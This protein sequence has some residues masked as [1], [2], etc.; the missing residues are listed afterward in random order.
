[1]KRTKMKNILSQRKIKGLSAAI[2]AFLGLAILLMSANAANAEIIRIIFKKNNPVNPVAS[3][4]RNHLGT[5][6]STK[7]VSDFFRASNIFINGNKFSTSGIF[8]INVTHKVIAVESSNPVS[9]KFSV[10]KFVKTGTSFSFEG[11]RKCFIIS[12]EGSLQTCQPPSQTPPQPPQ[13]LLLPSMSEEELRKNLIARIADNDVEAVRSLVALALSQN[14]GREFFDQK[15][16]DPELIRGHTYLTMIANL[17]G[18]EIF[19]IFLTIRDDRIDVNAP[20]KDEFTPLHT[21]ILARHFDIFSALLERKSLDVNAR[22]EGGTTTLM[23]AASMPSL[24]AESLFKRPE[25]DVDAR[26]RN[27]ESAL[28][29][30]VYMRNLPVV[31]ALVSRNAREQGN[32]EGLTPL[33]I[34][35]RKNFGELIPELL[36]GR[37]ELNAQELLEGIT[38]LHLAVHNADLPTVNGLLRY[39]ELNINLADSYGHTPLHLAVRKGYFE[40]VRALLGREDLDV[41]ARDTETKT[42]PIFIAFMRSNR[43]LIDILLERV[44]V[45]IPN[46]FGETPLTIALKNERPDLAMLTMQKDSNDVN[47][48]DV[49]GITALMIASHLGYYPLV[50]ELI[51]KGAEVNAVASGGGGS[52]ISK[53]AIGKSAL[54]AASSGN[55]AD[56]SIVTIV[57]TLL[58]AGADLNARDAEGNTALSIATKMG[59]IP[60]IAL[61]I[62]SKE[63]ETHGCSSNSLFR[64]CEFYHQLPE[65]PTEEMEAKE[66]A[67]LSTTEE[68]SPVVE[69]P[70][71][72][73]IPAVAVQRK[74]KR[75]KFTPF[76]LNKFA[77]NA[78][79]TTGV[80]LVESEDALS[81]VIEKQYQLWETLF[82]RQNDQNLFFDMHPETPVRPWQYVERFMRMAFLLLTNKQHNGYV[83][84]IPGQGWHSQEHGFSP[85]REA[86]IEFLD[87]EGIPYEI[88]PDNPGRIRIY[89][90]DGRPTSVPVPEET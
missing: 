26:D 46:I 80:P 32:G 71:S 56:A 57:K 55:P 3:E 68:P 11:S 35:I 37:L 83:T 63:I 49:D 42:T 64:L 67:L 21:S 14:R 52:E 1:M 61:L 77:P 54:H 66:A 78:F 44:D 17:G 50:Q 33:M 45:G 23:F 27:E 79:N 8:L 10:K 58:E 84:F 70:I 13:S 72:L 40:I 36:R 65:N 48:C 89:F 24:F 86:L 28:H 22:F 90:A 29:R 34:A 81:I 7:M 76:D 31:I 30:A 9:Y 60:L 25:L 6:I 82:Q 73:P 59:N 12:Q 4:I 43:P 2:F 75:W 62:R 69:V 47:A 20:G 88:D 87:R 15:I 74:H 41:N 16:P 85:L 38:T 18:K 51:K 19:Q 39:P 5:S 53:S